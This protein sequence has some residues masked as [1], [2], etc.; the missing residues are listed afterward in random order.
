M[1]DKLSVG[2]VPY[3]DDLQHPGDRRRLQIWA[4]AN[5]ID[6][7]T[8]KPLDSDVLILSNGA[9]FNYWIRRTKKPVILD[10]VDGYLGEEPSWIKDFAR[11][12]VRSV[13]GKSN[14]L[15]ITYT[16]AIKKACAASTAVIVAT[17]EQRE[18]VLPYNKSV[19]VILDDHSEL[20]RRTD[21]EET[22][23]ERFIF[24]EGYGYTLKHFKTISTE[25]DGFLYKN[26]FS[27]KLLTNSTF[28]KWGG[29]IGRVD[30]ASLIRKWFPK[31]FENIEIVPW[32]LSNVKLYADQSMFAII[33]I[34]TEDKFANLKPENKLLGLWALGLPVLF[35]DTPAYK[36]VARQAG[37]DSACL[38]RNDWALALENHESLLNEKDSELANKY[39]TDFHSKE[40][41]IEQ[42]DKVIRDSI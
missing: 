35:S 33:P 15:D 29:Y 7:E 2:Y 30:T 17:P 22:K 9:N 11:N 42:W 4:K 5:K 24:W 3:S 19:Y 16:R 28:A 8:N 39:L 36:R 14:L 37:I 12:I 26:N 31:S 32:T 23:K 13:N 18:S 6:L 20:R 40:L 34:D 27:L 38:T 21:L 10:L 41:L 25:L 1:S